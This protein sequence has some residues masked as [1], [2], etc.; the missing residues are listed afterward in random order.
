MTNVNKADAH[1]TI[2]DGEIEEAAR[3]PCQ[4][5]DVDPDQ[6]DEVEVAAWHPYRDEVAERL[7]RG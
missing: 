2:L 4:Q 3:Q 1:A 5:F 7:G 6:M